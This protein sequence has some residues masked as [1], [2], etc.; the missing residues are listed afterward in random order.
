MDALPFLCNCLQYKCQRM[1]L[2][3]IQEKSHLVPKQNKGRNL[4]ARQTVLQ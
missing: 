1:L 2:V 3:H 4:K